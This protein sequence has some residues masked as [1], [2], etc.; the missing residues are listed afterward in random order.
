MSATASPPSNAGRTTYVQAGGSFVTVTSASGSYTGVIT[1]GGSWVPQPVLALPITRYT[2]SPDPTNAEIARV[3]NQSQDELQRSTLPLRNIAAINSTIYRAYAFVLGETCSI[4][5][6]LGTANVGVNLGAPQSSPGV[7]VGQFGFDYKVDPANPT[8]AVIRPYGTFVCDVEFYVAPQITPGPLGPVPSGGTT[9][10]S[11]TGVVLAQGGSIISPAI[12]GTIGQVLTATGPTTEPTF[13]T[14]ASGGSSV[15]SGLASARPSATGSGA[16]Y[17]CTDIP[18][19]YFDSP[20]TSTWQQ[21]SSEY[22][23][24]PVTASSYTTNNISLSQY[25]DTIRAVVT[26]TAVDI[27]CALVPNSNLGATKIWTVNLTA[28]WIPYQGTTTSTA[29]DIAVVVTNGTTP[30]TSTGVGMVGNGAGGDVVFQWFG[31]NA[32]T[33]G[34]S[35]KTEVN[36]EFSSSIPAAGTGKL[37]MRLLN[38]G[39]ACHYQISNDGQN[40]LSWYSNASPSGM[41]DYGFA[42]GSDSGSGTSYSIALIYSNGVGTP[43]QYSCTGATNANPS[44]LTIGAHSIQVG[45]LVSVHGVSSTGTINTPIT[46]ENFTA[47]AAIVSAVTGTTISVSASGTITYSAGGTVTLLT[48]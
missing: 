35:T 1:V 27:Y 41:T 5:H 24:P 2:M 25:A 45:D 30:G 3:F 15:T 38:D 33:V 22:M 32:F 26:N 23:K 12:N 11:G 47:G 16:L 37:H 4:P 9:P 18:V 34:T 17:L 7:V 6:R 14:P 44:V 31:W 29:P 42:L 48:R 28:S 13:Q 21:F 39:Y 36:D 8:V 43:I 20:A 19:M 40:W 10:V 46:A